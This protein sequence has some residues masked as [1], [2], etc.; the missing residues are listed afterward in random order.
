ML[1]PSCRR[2]DCVLHGGGDTPSVSA[3]PI[4]A[5][6]DASLL[7]LDDLS[8]I[9]LEDANQGA[10][11]VVTA[12]IQDDRASIEPTTMPRMKRELEL[13]CDDGT[14][15][16]HIRLNQSALSDSPSGSPPTGVQPGGLGSA[17]GSVVSPHPIQEV[18][19]ATEV[20]PNKS[21]P[22][23]GVDE[24]IKLREKCQHFRVLVLGRANAGKTTLLKAVCGATGDPERIVSVHFSMIYTDHQIANCLSG[25]TKQKGRECGKWSSFTRS[26]LTYCR[27]R[28]T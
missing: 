1:C 20:A 18:R 22:P 5:L 27:T 15:N 16:E 21:H 2:Y 28:R 23:S 11:D 7:E 6:S 19:A 25:S 17:S 8:R 13:D 26:T 9:D 3:D 12:A 24:L 10:H 14:T 4:G